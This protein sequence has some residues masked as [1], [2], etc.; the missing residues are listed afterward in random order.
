MRPY[1]EKVLLAAGL[2]CF[3]LLTV[4]GRNTVTADLNINK[5]FTA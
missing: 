4:L 2:Y 3:N 1:A 5:I